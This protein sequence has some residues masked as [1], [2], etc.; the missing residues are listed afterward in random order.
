MPLPQPALLVISIFPHFLAF[1]SFVRKKISAYSTISCHILNSA[2]SPG[3]DM[4]IF[5]FWNC[6][7]TCMRIMCVY[8][9]LQGFDPWHA[10]VLCFHYMQRGSIPTTALFPRVAQLSLCISFKENN[11]NFAFIHSKISILISS[12]CMIESQIATLHQC[13]HLCCMYTCLFTWILSWPAESHHTYICVCT[14][15]CCMC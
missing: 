7:T 8:S 4:I 12:V 5:I 11:S 2:A 10:R 6:Q 14:H 13:M 3:A 15:V 9:H 1:M